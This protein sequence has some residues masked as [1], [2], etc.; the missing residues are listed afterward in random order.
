V[1]LGDMPEIAPDLIDRLIAAFAPKEGRS[2]V[3]PSA[4]GKRGNPVL[5][6]K[7]YFAEMAE[8]AGDTGAKHLLGAHAEDVVEIAANQSVHTDIDTPDA[9]SAL[10]KRLD[11]EQGDK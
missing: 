8:V 5:W 3:V 6:A 10:R 11:G 2:I 4:H 9:L 7:T 1:M